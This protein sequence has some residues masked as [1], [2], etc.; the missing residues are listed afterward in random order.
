MAVTSSKI[1]S[2]NPA[3]L[4]PLGSVLVSSPADVKNAIAAARKAQPAWQA[5]GVAGRVKELEKLYD[6]LAEK[7]EHFAQLETREMGRPI[8]GSRSSNAWALR[9]FQWNLKNAVQCLSPEIS[10]EDEKQVHEIHYE[11]YGVA[12]VITP[13]NF[14]LSNF[15]MGALQ[16]LLAGNT[17]VYKLSEEVPLFGK[18]LDQAWQDAQLPK[19]VF[20]QLFGAGDVGELL[21]RGDIDLLHFTGSSA[22]GKKLYMIAAEKFIPVT[23][24]LGGSDAGIVFEDADID[25]MVQPIFWAKF[26]NA[27]QICCGLKRLFV[28]ESRYKELVSK[29]SKFISEQKFGDPNDE[30]TVIGPLVSERQRERLA[31]QVADAKKKGVEVLLGGN[32]PPQSKGAYFEPTLL[33]KVN[34]DMRAYHEELFGPV[35][36]I[37]SFKSEAE[38]VQ[39]ANDTP[40]GLS[41]YVYTKDRD[42]Y[43]RVAAQLEAGSISH[44]GVDYSLP[45][46]PFGGYK[47]SGIGKTCGRIGLQHACRVKVIA[48]E[49]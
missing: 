40:Y 43:R 27:G 28:H 31:G 16:P 46:N 19:G 17:V 2:T 10:Y 1:D 12:G 13:W 34:Q 29:L 44:N 32:A 47:S 33:A 22:V 37:A 45:A 49:K 36:P 35:L 39:L 21:A 38:A 26:I 5:L 30:R 3:T 7:R 20:T 48:Q 4:E 18:A 25:R 15:V 8:Q 23:L 24:E 41:A 9:Q 42:R 11:P 14:P 6:Y